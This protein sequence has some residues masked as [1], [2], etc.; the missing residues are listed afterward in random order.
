MSADDV[1]AVSLFLIT[2]KISFN[3]LVFGSREHGPLQESP[4]L[5]LTESFSERQPGFLR[6]AESNIRQSYAESGSVACD[7]AFLR[8]MLAK[9]LNQAGARHDVS[10]LSI[11]LQ[12]DK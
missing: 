8:Q 2:Y 11:H 10:D 1:L 5:H 7:T 4:A 3:F 6:N 12:Y 9:G